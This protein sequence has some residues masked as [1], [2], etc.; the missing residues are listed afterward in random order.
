M[1]SLLPFGLFALIAPDLF[2]I[3]FGK[4]WRTA[5]EYAQILTPM[6]LLRFISNPLSNMFL[7]A[8]K[9]KLELLLQTILLLATGLCFVMGLMFE[10]IVLTICLISAI[11]TLMYAIMAL[12]SLKFAKGIVK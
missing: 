5:G 6:F 11:N 1:I 7:I 12:M 2:E 8:E 10:D 4:N 3:V 9:Q